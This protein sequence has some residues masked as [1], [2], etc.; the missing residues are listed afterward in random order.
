MTLREEILEI[1]YHEVDIEKVIQV[2]LKH[3]PKKKEVILEQGHITGLVG[4]PIKRIA[5]LRNEGWN[6]YRNEIEGK[7]Q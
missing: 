5:Q 2:F 3:L 6:A 1:I 4:D 7:L